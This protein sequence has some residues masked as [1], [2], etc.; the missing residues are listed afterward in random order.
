MRIV[1]Y[2]GLLGITGV[3]CLV[4][5]NF[6]VRDQDY[7]IMPG[8]YH[9]FTAGCWFSLVAGVLGALG[10]LFARSRSANRNVTTLIIS[11]G[12]SVALLAIWTRRTA[13]PPYAHFGEP[14]QLGDSPR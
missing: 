9:F 7:W 14:M 3:I 6:V 4:A 12:V 5:V 13:L 10:G 11:V 8:I 2:S 1:F